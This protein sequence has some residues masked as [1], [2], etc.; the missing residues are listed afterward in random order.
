MMR[1]MLA[2]MPSTPRRF[3]APSSVRSIAYCIPAR[4]VSMSSWRDGTCV[5]RLWWATTYGT[6][7]A[8]V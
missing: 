6:G 4:M 2:L 5:S 1:L 3:P 8:E 7:T